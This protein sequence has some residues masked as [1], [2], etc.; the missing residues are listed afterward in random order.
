MELIFC[1]LENEL[2]HLRHVQVWSTTTLKNKKKIWSTTLL[3]CKEVGVLI[4]IL[5]SLINFATNDKRTWAC[6]VEHENK[7][8]IISDSV[9]LIERTKPKKTKQKED[10]QK[11]QASAICKG[12]LFSAWRFTVFASIFNIDPRKNI[13]CPEKIPE[14]FIQW[15]LNKNDICIYKLIWKL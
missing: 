10:D 8:N 1:N 3:L 11:S 4:N 13:A 15:Y 12:W 7:S 14:S 2:V 9:F 5:I 6:R